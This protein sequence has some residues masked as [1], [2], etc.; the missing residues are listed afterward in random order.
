MFR[1]LRW[2]LERDVPPMSTPV[3]EKLS[4]KDIDE[5]LAHWAGKLHV[6]PDPLNRWA[7][8]NVCDAWLD[9]R[10]RLKELDER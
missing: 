7:H 1:W 6:D 4:V 5:V 9:A 3:D 10:N 8:L 2:L